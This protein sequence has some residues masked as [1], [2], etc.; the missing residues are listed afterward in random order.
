MMTKLVRC[1]G[2]LSSG[3]SAGLLL[4]V[5]AAAA[6]RSGPA[7]TKPSRIVSISRSGPASASIVLETLAVAVKEAGPKATVTEFGEVYAWSPA[8]FAVREGVPTKIRFW[9]PQ[10]DDMH[11]FELL[12]P[13]SRRLMLVPLPPLAK[14]SY[15]FDSTTRG[16]TDS[17]TRSM[18]PRWKG[19][20]LCCC[21]A[22]SYVPTR[23][24][25]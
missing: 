4:T 18:S 15:V 11:T 3:I 7:L 13:H 12:G 19:K 23:G 20:F 16:C 9:N 14:R 25:P 8:Y 1:L 6:S 17:C 5:S 10:P 22:L 21:R 2:V 24:S